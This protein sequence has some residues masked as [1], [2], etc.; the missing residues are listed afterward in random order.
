MGRQDYSQVGYGFTEQEARRNAINQAEDM[1][2]HQEG[3][4]GQ[5]NCSTGEEDRVK[6]LKRPKIA[7]TC[8]VE[9]IKQSGARKWKTVF[10]VTPQFGGEQ[11]IIDTTQADAIKEAKRL[12]LEN[13][14]QYVVLIDKQLAN[15]DMNVA[16]VTPKK[17]EKGEWLFT[18]IAR[19]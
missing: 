6:C 4:S 9:K 10:V 16:T 3:Y 19:C 14:T 13:Q 2:G 17:S 12:A 7:K 5:I 11:V 8:K 15:G 18:G 1:Y